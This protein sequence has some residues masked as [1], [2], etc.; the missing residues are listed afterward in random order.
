MKIDEAQIVAALLADGEQSFV[1]LYLA[2]V[3][4]GSPGSWTAV[5]TILDAVQA[6]DCES[7]AATG[8]DPDGPFYRLRGTVANPAVTVRVDAPALQTARR[9]MSID[10]TAIYA[11]RSKGTRAAALASSDSMST[12][13]EVYARRRRASQLEDDERKPR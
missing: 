4:A 10:S 11:R 6:L 12:A 7:R 1:T 9:A 5:Q 3:R 13:A 2:V 8:S